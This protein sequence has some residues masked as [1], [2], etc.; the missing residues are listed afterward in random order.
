[1][2]H[3]CVVLVWFPTGSSAS[4]LLEM[5]R[6]PEQNGVWTEDDRNVPG[7]RCCALLPLS[8]SKSWGP[9]R[10]GGSV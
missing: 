7:L 5:I 9:K 1:M 6:L 4:I 2:T 10:V 3:W 8:C